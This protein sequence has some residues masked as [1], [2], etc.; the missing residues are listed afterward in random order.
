[1][2]R[3]LEV[4]TR[5]TAAGLHRAQVDYQLSIC[6]RPDSEEVSRQERGLLRATTWIVAI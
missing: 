4:V 1:M 6:L 3:E 5:R 2:V